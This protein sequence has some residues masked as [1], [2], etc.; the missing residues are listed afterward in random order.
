MHKLQ[1]WPT[2]RK[3]NLTEFN[4]VTAQAEREQLDPTNYIALRFLS[5]RISD[6]MFTLTCA[7]INFEDRNE[8][9]LA[10]DIA[11]L[12][13]TVEQLQKAIRSIPA[14]YEL[15]RRK[16]VRTLSSD[17]DTDMPKL[18]RLL[19]EIEGHIVREKRSI[20]EG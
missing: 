14:N 17:I 7:R 13:T 2:Q 1:N 8:T 20:L 6:T 12:K 15:L 9:L 19:P 11:Q 16:I 5:D 18:Y 3:A 10:E 4:F